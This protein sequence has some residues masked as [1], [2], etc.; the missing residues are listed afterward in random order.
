M[1]LLQLKIPPDKAVKM[2]DAIESHVSSGNA[3]E[4]GPEL[5]EIVIWLRYRI[6]RWYKHHPAA[7]AA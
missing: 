1:D 5:A 7:P 2:A 4:N 3:G 6:S